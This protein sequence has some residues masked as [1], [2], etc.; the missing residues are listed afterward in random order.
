MFTDTRDPP[1]G[2]RQF[3]SRLGKTVINAKVLGY[4]LM[5]LIPVYF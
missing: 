2:D 5:V 3:L 4:V 1:H